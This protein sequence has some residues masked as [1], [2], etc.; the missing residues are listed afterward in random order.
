MGG[1]SM[2]WIP[3]TAMGSANEARDRA[4]EVRDL[5]NAWCCGSAGG[6]K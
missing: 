1:E 6:R 3:C 2:P 5:G 4:A